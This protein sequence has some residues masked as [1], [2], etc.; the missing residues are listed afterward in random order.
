MFLAFALLTE[1]LSESLWSTV[2]S[3]FV[4]MKSGPLSDRSGFTSP[5][6]GP[7]QLLNHGMKKRL[8]PLAKTLV[9][10]HVWQMISQKNQCLVSAL[11][12]GLDHKCQEMPWPLATA[13]CKGL[14]GT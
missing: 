1:S 3:L 13:C 4:H 11:P 6:R 2:E 7:S 9:D 14:Q 5:L 12:R 10:L 8:P